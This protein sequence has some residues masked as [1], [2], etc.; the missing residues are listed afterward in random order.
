MYDDYVPPKEIK[1]SLDPYR[2]VNK[3]ISKGKAPAPP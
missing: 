2:K 1:P 3:I